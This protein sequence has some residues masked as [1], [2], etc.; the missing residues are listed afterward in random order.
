MGILQYAEGRKNFFDGVGKM[1]EGTDIA[2]VLEASGLD[3]TVRKEQMY[4]Q[5]GT[6]AKDIYATVRDMDNERVVLGHVGKQYTV[7]QNIDAFNFLDDIT[8]TGDVHIVNA[9][10]V[11]N[12]KRAYICAKTEPFKVLDDD[13]DPYIV[14]MNSFDGCG[15]VKVMFTPVRVFCSNCEVVA[16]KRASRCISV[17]HS[18]QVVDNLYVAATVLF[19]NT[20][21]LKVYKEEMEQL[22]TMRLSRQQFADNLVKA[23]LQ[24]INLLDENGEIKERKR[25]PEVAIRYRDELL[26]CWSKSDLANYGNTAYAAFQAI[27]DW[28]THYSPLKNSNNGEIYF[29]RAIKGMVLTNWALQYMKN[30]MSLT[31]TVL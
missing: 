27:S 31:K 9:G 22:A 2:S 26:N 8:R 17:K 10:N 19:S 23:L 5:D 12:G 3:Y 1:M 16:T 29:Q 24:H 15:S 6:P 13:I 21:Y 11:D 25:D 28:E 14:F 7:L 4:F 18:R 30:N 20:E